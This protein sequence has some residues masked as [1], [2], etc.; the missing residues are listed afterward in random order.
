MLYYLKG[1]VA[2]IID[3]FD[4]DEYTYTV[5]RDIDP[6]SINKNVRVHIYTLLSK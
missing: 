3:I 2:R 5:S 4:P 6:D 1:L